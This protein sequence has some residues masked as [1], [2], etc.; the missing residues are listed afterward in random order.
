M[1]QRMTKQKKAI[2][3]YLISVKTHPTAEIIHKAI[4]K[5][6]PNISLGTIYRN[7]SQLVENKQ[8]IKLE[9]NGE[10]RFDAC[11]D[12]HQHLICNV[13][14]KIIDATCKKTHSALLAEAKN[15]D[16]QAEETTVYITGMCSSCASKMRGK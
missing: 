8:I 4:S 7:L 2:L 14:G 15:N 5:E 9:L 12:S 11:K 13:C 10:S 6:I 3:D 16:F 1:N